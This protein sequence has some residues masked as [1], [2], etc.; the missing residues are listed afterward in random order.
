M[1]NSWISSIVAS[2]QT[3]GLVL[4]PLGYLPLGDLPL[5]L[6]LSDLKWAFDRGH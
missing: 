1:N 3:V 2:F 4:S 5:G 6:C